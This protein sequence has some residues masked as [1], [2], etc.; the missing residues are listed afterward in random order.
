MFIPDPDPDLSISDPT[1]TTKERGDIFVLP[2]RSNKFH[3]IGNYF[4][5]ELL[6]NKIWA[7][8]QRIIELFIQKLSLSSQK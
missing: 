1:T 4:I 3:K 8:F 7:N 6:K 2:F 5:F